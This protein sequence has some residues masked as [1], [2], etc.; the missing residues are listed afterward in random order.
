MYGRVSEPAVRGM[1]K[2][3]NLDVDEAARLVE[4]RG[5]APAFGGTA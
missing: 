1:G 3:D 4:G 5:V 2:V